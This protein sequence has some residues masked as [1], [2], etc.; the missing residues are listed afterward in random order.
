MQCSCL[1]E[2]CKWWEVQFCYIISLSG[3]FWWFF[4]HLIRKSFFLKL[5]F[6]FSFRS[7]FCMNW[8]RSQ[9]KFGIKF[10]GK[11]FYISLYLL[12]ILKPWQDLLL[13]VLLLKVALV[14]FHQIPA[15]IVHLLTLEPLQRYFYFFKKM[16]CV[17]SDLQ[18]VVVCSQGRIKK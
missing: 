16:C 7:S 8:L 17:S 13:L 2:H 10:R 3:G 5:S 15:H 6:I 11:E 14:P 18:N 4:L 9:I 12:S 1:S